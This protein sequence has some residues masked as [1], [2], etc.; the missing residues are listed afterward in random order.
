MKAGVWNQK[1]LFQQRWQPTESAHNSVFVWPQ[2]QHSPP[3]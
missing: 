3:E 2:I 1:G